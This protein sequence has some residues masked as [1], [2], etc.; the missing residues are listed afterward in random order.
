MAAVKQLCT[1]GI[2]LRNGGLAF[3]GN[4]N[5]AVIYYQNAHQTNSSFLHE[6]QLNEAP[7]NE[8]IRILRFEVSPLIGDTLSISSG[9]LFELEFY[10]YKA[11][12][13]L[14]ATFELKSTDEVVVFHHGAI[15]SQHNNSKTGI[16][17]VKGKLPP[18]LLNAGTFIFDLIFGENQRYALFVIKDIIQFEVMNENI[19]SNS[20]QLP[21]LLRPD[22]QYTILQPGI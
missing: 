19:G 16:Y 18:H 9:I 3:S 8:N 6:G 14:D 7:G 21:G 22:I 5:E 4:Q 11:G 17:K 1:K 13:N 20:S 15:L 12:I 2:V 10:N